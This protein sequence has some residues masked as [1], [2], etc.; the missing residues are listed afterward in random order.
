[1]NGKST[2]DTAGNWPGSQGTHRPEELL[3]APTFV[4]GNQFGQPNESDIRAA[5][6]SLE[7]RREDEHSWN[8]GVPTV[9]QVI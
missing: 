4:A 2:Y 1:M 9:Y 7:D 5:M 6:T 3:N 8:F